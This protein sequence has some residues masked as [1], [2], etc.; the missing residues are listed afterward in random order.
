MNGIKF[1]IFF[2]EHKLTEYRKQKKL[3]AKKRKHDELEEFQGDSDMAAM[4]GFAG[5]SGGPK[6]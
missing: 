3:D 6:K 4:M 2:Q 1:E 5:F